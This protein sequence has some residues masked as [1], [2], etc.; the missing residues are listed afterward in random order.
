M[1]QLP[2]RVP[3][4]GLSTEKACSFQLYISCR[5]L[6]GLEEKDGD[7][8]KI[9]VNEVL[10]LMCHIR[11][12]I[13]PN[14]GMPSRI[15]LLVKFFLDECSNVLLD[16]VLL[17]SLCGTIDRVLLHVFGHIGVLDDSFAIRHDLT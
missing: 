15:V 10:R 4:S 17:K 3:S 6:T 12:K 16:V 8:T 2:L 5:A 7:L 11:A 1:I 13:A 9:E 14:N